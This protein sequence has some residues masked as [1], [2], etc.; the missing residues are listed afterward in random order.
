M[1]TVSSLHVFIQ[2]YI[3]MQCFAFILHM[4]F[5]TFIGAFMSAMKHGWQTQDLELLLRRYVS[6]LSQWYFWAVLQMIIKSLTVTWLN[7]CTDLIITLKSKHT[8]SARSLFDLSFPLIITTLIV[9]VFKGNPF[10]RPSSG[11]QNMRAKVKILQ[12]Q[13]F[14]SVYS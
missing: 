1:C 6:F 12:G 14:T 5:L 10:S 3:N 4:H 7:W 11:N 2:S 8:D 9:L 13:D